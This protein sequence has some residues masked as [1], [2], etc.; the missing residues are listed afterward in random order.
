MSSGLILLRPSPVSVRQLYPLGTP[1]TLR[2]LD[3]PRLLLSIGTPFTTMSG[4]LLAPKEETPRMLNLAT[5][6]RTRPKAADVDPSYFALQGIHEFGLAI[7]GH[8][9][10]DLRSRRHI[11]SV[12][13]SFSIPKGGYDYLIKGSGVLNHIDVNGGATID[14]ILPGWC[15]R[16]RK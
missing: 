3:T 15:S 1:P 4:E 5:S 12:F 9:V 14:L 16:Y 8:F 7:D 13:R 2:S 11:P 10:R 6:L